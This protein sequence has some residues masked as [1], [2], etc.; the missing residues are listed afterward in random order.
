MDVGGVSTFSTVEAA[1]LSMLMLWRVSTG[2]KKKCTIFCRD[3]D[4]CSKSRADA[5]RAAQA[6]QCRKPPL[7]LYMI[8]NRL[9][10]YHEQALS[11]FYFFLFFHRRSYG[12]ISQKWHLTYTCVETGRRDSWCVS[13]WE[14]EGESHAA[15]S[16]AREN[17]CSQA[18]GK[19]TCVMKLVPAY[20]WLFVIQ[21]VEKL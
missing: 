4:H 16:D 15:P 2:I 9:C 8:L 6:T 17:S 14:N 11:F 12:F 18:M 13:M 3:E 7:S 1:K 10:C 19:W 5:R 20:N 21:T